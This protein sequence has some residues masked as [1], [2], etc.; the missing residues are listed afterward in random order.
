MCSSQIFTLNCTASNSTE[1][2]NA[3]NATVRASY[4]M[5]CDAGFYWL[6]PWFF[7]YLFVT[8]ISVFLLLIWKWSPMAC[9]YDC[10]S[11]AGF[12]R[13]TWVNRSEILFLC[14]GYG[15]FFNLTMNTEHIG[16]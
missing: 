5:E 16:W 7:S 2:S 13:P 12:I 14:L 1:T 6:L 9:M 4:S 8:I 3:T 11:F 15:A 10:P